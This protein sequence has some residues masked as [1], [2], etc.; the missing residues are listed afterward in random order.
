M[1]N[2]CQ[3]RINILKVTKQHFTEAMEKTLHESK[4]QIRI[5][6]EQSEADIAKI[7]G[8]R[9]DT[10]SGDRII[11]NSQ[12]NEPIRRLLSTTF[13]SV[14]AEQERCRVAMMNLRD[15][16]ENVIDNLTSILVLDQEN[17]GHLNFLV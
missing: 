10:L 8:D 2:I 4:E 16:M 14:A 7:T 5:I 12:I 6:T 1:V 17:Y 9:S 15:E 11:H 13:E 3:Q